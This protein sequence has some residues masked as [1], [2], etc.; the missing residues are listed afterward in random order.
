MTKPIAYSNKAAGATFVTTAFPNFV[1]NVPSGHENRY[2]VIFISLKTTSSGISASSTVTGTVGGK[3]L[4]MLHQVQY[5]GQASYVAMLGVK[6]PPLGNQ[7]VILS[8]SNIGGNAHGRAWGIILDNVDLRN[9][10]LSGSL[11]STTAMASVAIT[12]GGQPDTTYGIAIDCWVCNEVFNGGSN[13][14]TP[15]SASMVSIYSGS[16]QNNLR[17]SYGAAYKKQTVGTDVTASM[18]W[19]ITGSSPYH[20]GMFLKAAQRD[21][22][23]QVL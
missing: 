18:D 22:P 1:L 16:V 21:K 10:V 15:A 4:T 17:M 12:C 7:T 2:A 8:P 3:L 23:I 13:G 14:G 5:I 11:L 19:T 9:P 20:I 6:M